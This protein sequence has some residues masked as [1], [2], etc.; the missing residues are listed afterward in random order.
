MGTDV[1]GVVKELQNHC[2]TKVY[3]LFTTPFY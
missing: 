1:T 3:N 2:D